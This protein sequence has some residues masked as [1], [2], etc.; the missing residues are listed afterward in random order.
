MLHARGGMASVMHALWRASAT[1]KGPSRAPPLSSDRCRA[2]TDG[3]SASSLRT[4]GNGHP[5]RSL[6]QTKQDDAVPPSHD[7][8]AGCCCQ[9]HDGHARIHA[10]VTNV[11]GC[12]DPLAQ[13]QP[14]G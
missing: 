2:L 14:P 10:A 1:R 13:I 6:P 5:Q 7:A 3:A 11:R 4:I 12:S 9:H 8:V